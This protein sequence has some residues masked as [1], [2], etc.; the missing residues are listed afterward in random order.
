MLQKRGI[1]FY[2]GFKID[3]MEINFLNSILI[4]C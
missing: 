1:K 3:F 4:K 2:N